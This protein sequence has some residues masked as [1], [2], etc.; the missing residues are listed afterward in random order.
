MWHNYSV[1]GIGASLR[2]TSEKERPRP[3]IFSPV[4]SSM[5]SHHTDPCVFNTLETQHSPSF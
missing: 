2:G 1:I 4:V 3:S 5:S